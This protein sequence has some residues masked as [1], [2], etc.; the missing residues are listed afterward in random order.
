MKK[1]YVPALEPELLGVEIDSDSEVCFGIGSTTHREENSSYLTTI[2]YL[3]VNGQ[4]FSLRAS[5]IK[6]VVEI[7][8]YLP[9]RLDEDASDSSWRELKPDE[10]KPRFIH[11]I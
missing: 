9:V 1:I 7:I 5:G 6:F 2:H 4:G 3:K 11:V 10:K 8:D